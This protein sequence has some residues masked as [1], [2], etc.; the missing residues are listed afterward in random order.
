MQTSTTVKLHLLH[1]QPRYALA[2]VPWLAVAG[3]CLSSH[4]A[5]VPVMYAARP[6]YSNAV[7]M[8]LH[9]HSCWP[10]SLS[11]QAYLGRTSRRLSIVDSLKILV[12]SNADQCTCAKALHLCH[13]RDRHTMQTAWNQAEVKAPLTFNEPIWKLLFALG[14]S[15]APAL[16]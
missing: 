16:L 9:E 14:M 11:K 1:W 8:V 3:S 12:V 13:Q 15:G 6:A 10:S 7:T 2:A 4:L 5:T